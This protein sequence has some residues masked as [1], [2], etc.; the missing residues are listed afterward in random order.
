MN[1]ISCKELIAQLFLLSNVMDNYSVVSRKEAFLKL[2]FILS[3]SR[4]SMEWATRR[5]ST[6][7]ESNPLTL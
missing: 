6:V 2:V 4:L 7:G 1:K 3:E 5:R